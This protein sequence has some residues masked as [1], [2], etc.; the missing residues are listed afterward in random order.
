MSTSDAPTSAAARLA[1][2]RNSARGWHGVQLA[3]IGF[4]GLCGVLKPQDSAAP[5]WV[6][7]VAAA[8]ALAALVLACLATYLV[9]RAAWPLYDAKRAAAPADDAGELL[10]TSHRLTRG[11]AL[12]FVAVALLALSAGSFWWPAKDAAAAGSAQGQAQVQVEAQG[13]TF[14]GQLADARAGAV[15]VVTAEQPVEIPIQS[16]TAIHPVDGC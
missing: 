12:T 6:E 11:L 7:D 14:C 2:L 9:G 15:R 1:E 16:L 13:S 10:R 3:V 5:K 4:I 8:L